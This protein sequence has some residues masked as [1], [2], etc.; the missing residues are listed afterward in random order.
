MLEQLLELKRRREQRLRQAIVKGKQHDRQL[1][2]HRQALLLEREALQQEWRQ[3][4]QQGGRLDRQDFYALQR[5][6]EGYFCRDKTLAEE[7]ANIERQRAEWRDELR[8]IQSQLRQ[9]ELE[10]EKLHIMVEQSDAY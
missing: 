4:G 9:T 2:N 1:K 5:Q 3:Q 7:I 10:R 6:L 8:D